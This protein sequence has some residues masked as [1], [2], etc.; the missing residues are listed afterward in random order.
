[1][2]LKH[3]GQ[4]ILGQPVK[5]TLPL[6][7]NSRV[8]RAATEYTGFLSAGEVVQIGMPPSGGLEPLELA[9]RL[10]ILQKI[11]WLDE[12]GVGGAPEIWK[13]GRAV[14][15]RGEGRP[16]ES[17]SSTA[18]Q[19]GQDRRR[20]VP[21]T[22]SGL[23]TGTGARAPFSQTASLSIADPKRQLS[24]LASL[25]LPRRM[26]QQNNVKA[27]KRRE[28]NRKYY[29]MHPEIKERNRARIAARWEAKK[30]YRRQWDPPRKKR[31]AVRGDGSLGEDTEELEMMRNETA[32]H[33]ALS[34]MYRLNIHEKAAGPPA[35]DKRKEP[36]SLAEIEAYKSSRDDSSHGTV[37]EAPAPRVTTLQT[38]TTNRNA[39]AMLTL[40][41]HLDAE[42]AARMRIVVES[43]RSFEAVA[44]IHQER[45]SVEV[46][47]WLQGIEACIT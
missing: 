13:G 30:K 21:A 27:S 31:L 44:S 39:D 14:G 38:A 29:E 22:Q 47:K 7:P 3:N 35:P 18:V 40:E 25:P 10:I 33:A 43:S 6:K 37:N 45:G 2:G 8:N 17:R 9:K 11:T 42:R 36:K 15:R 41:A 24:S 32:A 28:V 19:I 5:Q 34:A 46:Q 1:M 4:R 26:V 16:N 20:L 23:Q 12:I